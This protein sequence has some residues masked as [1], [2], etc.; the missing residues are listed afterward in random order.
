MHNRDHERQPILILA[1]TTAAVFLN[2]LFTF[3]V[4][5]RVQPTVGDALRGARVHVRSP[6]LVGSVV[7]ALLA[8]SV[9]VGAGLQRPLFV[10]ALSIAVGLLM[11]S[12]SRSRRGCCGS[13]SAAHAATGP[14]RVR[15]A[16]RCRL[17]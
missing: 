1:V 9:T 10:L 8:A 2:V 15:S 4:S 12:T 11:S 13:S 3:A 5:E 6:V 17:S 16:L 7:G 14:S